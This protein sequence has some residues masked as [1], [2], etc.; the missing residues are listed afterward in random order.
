MHRIRPLLQK[1]TPSGSLTVVRAIRGDRK[2]LRRRS[3]GIDAVLSAM[4]AASAGGLSGPSTLVADCA[5]ATVQAMAATGITRLAIVS[6]AV[7]FRRRVFFL[8]S[9]DGF[10]RHHARATSAPWKASYNQAGLAMDDRAS[11]P[12]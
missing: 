11:A 7:L 10:L 5:R 9:S 8:L 3:L 6:A 4:R 2:R 12:G 1:L